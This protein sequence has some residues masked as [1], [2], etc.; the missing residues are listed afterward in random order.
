MSESNHPTKEQQLSEKRIWLSTLL[1]ILIPFTPY[2]YTQRWK[3]LLYFLGGIFAVAMATTSV[4]KSPKDP[5]KAF[6]K[7]YQQGSTYL[8]PVASLVALT[9]NWVAISRARKKQKGNNTNES[10]LDS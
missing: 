5:E 9:D 10:N 4:T 6:A 3:P 1:A 7:G 8:A 2:L